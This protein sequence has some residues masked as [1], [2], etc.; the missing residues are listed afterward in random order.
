L[1]NFQEA[2][3]FLIINI[4]NHQRADRLR[5]L[6]HEF[7]LDSELAARKPI[8]ADIYVGGTSKHAR[9]Q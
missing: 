9:E 2:S 3:L 1:F 4:L 6:R 5:Q 8:K 7:W